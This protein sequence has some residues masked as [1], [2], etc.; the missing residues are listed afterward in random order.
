MMKSKDM[1]W[2]DHEPGDPPIE[3]ST[4][5]AS[6]DAMTDEEIHA[7]A[8]S[9]PDAQ[10]LPLGNDEEMAK[11]GLI[12]IPNVKKLRERLG[13]TQEAFAAAYRIPIGTLR[14]WE[15]CRKRPDAPARAYLTVIARNPEAVAGLLSQA[16]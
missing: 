16:A 15:Q 2:V 10:P 5:W 8:L 4:D 9:D 7:A 11:L 14:D 3:T 12:H 13:L 6:V 1:V